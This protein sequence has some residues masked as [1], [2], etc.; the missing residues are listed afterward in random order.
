MAT[1]D[2]TTLNQLSETILYE[3]SP[4]RLPL[5]TAISLVIIDRL[6]LRG[7]YFEALEA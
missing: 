3:E 6:G 2:G 7:A 1:M 4:K 5:Q